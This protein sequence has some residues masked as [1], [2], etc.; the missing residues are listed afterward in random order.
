MR[1]ETYAYGQSKVSLAPRLADG[2]AGSF[3]W[4]GDVSELQV[5]LNVEDFTHKESYSGN[6]QEVRKIIVGKSGEVSIKFHE[7]SSENLSLMLFGDVVKV[8]AGT[9]SDGKLPSEIAAGDRIAL[10]HQN[11]SNVQIATL[12][13]NQDFA[14]DSIFGVIEFLKPQSNFTKKINYNYGEVENVAMLNQ[15]PKELYLRFEGVNLAE[16]NE[17]NL[18]E[19][20]KISFN[21]TDALSLINSEN[22]L[23]SLASKAKVLADTTKIGDNKLGRFGRIVKIKK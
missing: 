19:L 7:L 14:V 2:S 6:R 12:T 15:E 13:E 9:V 18:V 20:Y 11:I 8:Q 5:S 1:S 3:R 4:V 22:S 21:P 10:P 16:T 17:W 23:A